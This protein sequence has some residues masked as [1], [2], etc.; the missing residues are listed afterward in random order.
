[1]SGIPLLIQIK[2][3]KVKLLTDLNRDSTNSKRKEQVD[4]QLYKTIGGHKKKKKYDVSLIS[5]NGNTQLN[6]TMQIK[7]SDWS[8]A[9]FITKSWNTLSFSKK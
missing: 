1:M 6:W 8:R 7:R 2:I 9:Y 4:D 3:K 5:L